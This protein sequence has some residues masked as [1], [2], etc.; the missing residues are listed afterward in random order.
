MLSLV[1]LVEGFV[2]GSLGLKVEFMGGFASPL[3]VGNCLVVAG[4]SAQNSSV[5]LEREGIVFWLDGGVVFK[6]GRDGDGK[7]VRGVMGLGV[8]VG[9]LCHGRFR[10]SAY[11][12]RHAIRFREF[13]GN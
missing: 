7:M 3:S 4:A 6:I 5:G 8:L 9:V 2:G 12:P 11:R 10:L 1:P 13:D